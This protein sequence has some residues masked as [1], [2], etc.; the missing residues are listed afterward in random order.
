[1]LDKISESVLHKLI[2]LCNGKPETDLKFNVSDFDN[3]LNKDVLTML[4]KDLEKNEYLEYSCPPG[5]GT[6]FS[7]KLTYKG[8][9]YFERKQAEN[10][11]FFK[12]SVLLP[13]TITIVTQ[14]LLWGA[15]ELHDAITKQSEEYPTDYACHYHNNYE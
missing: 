15:K 12:R 3:S 4:L 5:Y 10:K 14:L 6:P 1:M 9:A 2:E 13:I 7:A 8:Y 11:F